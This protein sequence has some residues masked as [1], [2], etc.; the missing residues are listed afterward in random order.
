MLATALLIGERVSAVGMAAVAALSI[1]VF[2]MSLRGARVGGFEGA[3]G[4]NGAALCGL[5][6]RLHTGRRHWCARER[7][8]PGYALWMLEVVPDICTG[9]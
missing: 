3:R 1:G 4:S 8:G 2:L 9:R 5:H 6:L 7:S